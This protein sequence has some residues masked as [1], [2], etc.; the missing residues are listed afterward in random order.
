MQFT[1]FLV[2]LGMCVQLTAVS[3]GSRQL[4][5]LSL[6]CITLILVPPASAPPRWTTPCLPLLSSH[7]GEP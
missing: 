2:L 7:P 6:P 4:H 5:D 1:G 3:T